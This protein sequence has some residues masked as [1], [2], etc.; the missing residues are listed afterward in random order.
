MKQ[1]IF[2]FLAS[3]GILQAQDELKLLDNLIEVTQENL[4]R[5][6]ALRA[7]VQEYLKELDLYLKNPQNKDLALKIGKIAN[8]ALETIKDLQLAESFEPQ[9]ISEMTLFAQL[10][11]KRGIP[12]P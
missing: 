6:K 12:K 11:Q 3:F 4:A 7:E 10:A 5:E 1:I 9:F 2:I 8:K